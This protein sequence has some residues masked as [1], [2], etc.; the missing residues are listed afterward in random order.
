MELLEK[1][2]AEAEGLVDGSERGDEDSGGVV[3]LE[4][5]GPLEVGEAGGDVLSVGV[6]TER[7]A[8]VAELHGD[9]VE[10]AVVLDVDLV[11]DLEVN[12]LEGVQ[13]SVDNADRAGLLELVGERKA[14]Q[15]SQSV[16][17]N[18][19]DLVELR[20]VQV[21]E[22]LASVEVEGTTDLA[23]AV[24]GEGSELGDVA[25]NEVTSDLTDIVNLNVVGGAGGDG[26]GT[27]EGLA[28]GETGG[29]TLVLDG[30]GS[31]AAGRL[32]WLVVSQRLSGVS[33]R[34]VFA[35]VFS[36][37]PHCRRWPR[38]ARCT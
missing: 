26:D 11:G 14:L 32:S 33:S 20:E 31:G 6:D 23:Q 18:L 36:Y 12:A 34:V 30:G 7:L 17:L 9:V 13:L 15:T 16:P 25:R 4:G 8:D 5:V 38:R 27:R 19:V 22:D 29:I 37:L 28:R 2:A 21:G 10:V 35:F 1:V 24:G 3:D